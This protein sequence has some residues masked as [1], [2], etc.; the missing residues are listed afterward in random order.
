MAKRSLLKFVLSLVIL[1]VVL[2]IVAV[3]GAWMVVGRGA[4]GP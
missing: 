4:V 3:I 1:F 2:G